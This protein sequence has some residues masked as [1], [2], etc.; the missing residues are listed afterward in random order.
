MLEEH[1]ALLNTPKISLGKEASSTICCPCSVA[2][3]KEKYPKGVRRTVS[4]PRLQQSCKA[5]NPPVGATITIPLAKCSPLDNPPRFARG[6]LEPFP[7]GRS[8]F[9]GEGPPSSCSGHVYG[10][11]S[12]GRRRNRRL[13]G[14]NP[15]HGSRREWFNNRALRALFKGREGFQE[16][17]LEGNKKHCF[18][19]QTLEEQHN[20]AFHA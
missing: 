15:G 5:K 18:A 12:N 11:L 19:D 3:K 9:G 7:K 20:T 17:N 14:F 13:L 2:L 10:V 4:T 8:P 6:D 16:D 1:L